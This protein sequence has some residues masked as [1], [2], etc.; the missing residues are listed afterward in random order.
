[1]QRNAPTVDGLRVTL[2]R[3]ITEEMVFYVTVP[4][5]NGRFRLLGTMKRKCLPDSVRDLNSTLSRKLNALR[6][7]MHVH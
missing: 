3:F 5:V 7:F 1:M 6:G 2:A 4:A